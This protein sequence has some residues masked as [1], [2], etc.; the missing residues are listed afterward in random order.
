M[1]AVAIEVRKA[2]EWLGKA[3]MIILILVKDKDI[4][5]APCR[6][7]RIMKT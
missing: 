1:V 2:E 7:W 3:N 4:I 6:I 5:E